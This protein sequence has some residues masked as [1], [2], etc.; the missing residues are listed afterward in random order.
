MN[1]SAT[2]VI[3]DL[4][5]RIN[6]LTEENGNLLMQAYESEEMVASLKA[7]ALSKSDS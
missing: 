4:L 3:H 7:E 6:D 1:L 2:N 5:S